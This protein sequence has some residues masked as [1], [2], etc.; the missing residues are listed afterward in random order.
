MFL[1][2]I[3]VDPWI[4]S[5]KI[6]DMLNVTS[7]ENAPLVPWPNV[8]VCNLTKFSVIAKCLINSGL[9]ALS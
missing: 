8:W 2:F 3:K 5:D 4:D 7:L 9:R 6:S 1:Y